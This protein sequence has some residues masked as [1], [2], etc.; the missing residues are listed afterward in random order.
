MFL[1]PR[2]LNLGKIPRI[3]KIRKGEIKKSF[4]KRAPKAFLVNPLS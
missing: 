4:L 3:L 2:N 1:P